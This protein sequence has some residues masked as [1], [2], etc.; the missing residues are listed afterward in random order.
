MMEYR[1]EIDGANYSMTEL[2]SVTITQPLFERFS[3]GN[4]CSAELKISFSPKGTI[5]RMARIVPFARKSSEDEWKQLGVFYTDTRTVT[6][7]L[8][9]ITAYDEML[10]AE[11]VWVPRQ[12]LEFPETGLPMPDAVTE[13]AHLMDVP[14]DSRTALNAAY[15]IDY[16]A[17]DY[18]LRDVL[19][20]IAAAHGGNWIITAE[21]TL[22]L[23][24]LFGS[25]P[26]ETHYLVTES[27]NV[28]TFG[29]VRILI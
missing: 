13:I 17:N 1:V 19:R 15:G 23:V 3:V 28:I 14:V 27:G 16:P 18:T 25:M 5:S 9:E 8:M 11:Q 29:G 20:Y 24:P 4:A 7:D 26:P 6:G 21:R 12:D 22:L 2:Y 10:K